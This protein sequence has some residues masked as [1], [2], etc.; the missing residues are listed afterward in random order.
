[1]KLTQLRIISHHLQMH[2]EASR[3]VATTYYYY[4]DAWRSTDSAKAL[5]D[6]EGKH[7]RSALESPDSRHFENKRTIWFGIAPLSAAVSLKCKK[8]VPEEKSISTATN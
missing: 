3:V 5:S 6:H 4:Q 8:S 2:F 7:P 1:M